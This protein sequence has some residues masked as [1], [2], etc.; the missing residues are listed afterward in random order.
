MDRSQYYSYPISF[1]IYAEAKRHTRE[2]RRNSVVCQLGVLPG[3]CHSLGVAS[4][5]SYSLNI[6]LS[7]TNMGKPQ[8]NCVTSTSTQ[9]NIN[10]LIGNKDVILTSNH[11]SEVFYGRG[12]NNDPTSSP[13]S[14]DTD[15][16]S[17]YEAIKRSTG[18]SRRMS[19]QFSNL[20]DFR[21]INKQAKKRLSVQAMTSSCI[22]MPTSAPSSKR[23][24]VC[25]ESLSLFQEI[26][27]GSSLLPR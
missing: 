27:N 12:K 5:S 19:E 20:N 4:Q 23:E 14:D 22:L 18:K 3:R 9:A 1:R 13:S 7:T 26:R 17:K 25:D 2:I 16:A 10:C 24:D 8:L 21:V 15:P 6:M 11:Q